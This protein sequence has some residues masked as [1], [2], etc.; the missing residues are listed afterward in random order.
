VV[1]VPAVAVTSSRMPKRPVASKAIPFNSPAVGRPTKLRAWPFAS[2]A[3]TPGPLPNLSTYST[4]A[5]NEQPT[6]GSLRWVESA[7]YGSSPAGDEYPLGPAANGRT[8]P[9]RRM[10]ARCPAAATVSVPS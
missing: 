4:S 9:P 6:P 10:S 1:F 3:V 2:T 5:P 7:M 8:V